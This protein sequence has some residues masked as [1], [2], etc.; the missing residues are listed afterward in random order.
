M[1]HLISTT[2]TTFKLG[3]I[4]MAYEENLLQTHRYHGEQSVAA[5]RK[6]TVQT[7]EIFI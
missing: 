4:Y 3:V 2:A 1:A 7:I 5:T 6:K